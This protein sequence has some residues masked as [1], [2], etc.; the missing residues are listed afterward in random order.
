MENKLDF[1]IRNTEQTDM[2]FWFYLDKHLSIVDGS[3]KINGTAEPNANP[4]TGVVLPYLNLGEYITFEYVVKI[5]S[6]S[7]T[8]AVTDSAEFL[9][10]VTDPDNE[11]TIQNLAPSET[12]TVEFD[13]K[14]N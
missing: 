8:T 12:L 11:F 7:T 6:P 2:D 14:V 10:T 5:N 4:V 9:Y 1:V 3:V 13:V